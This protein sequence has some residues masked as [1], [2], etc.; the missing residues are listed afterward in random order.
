MKHAPPALPELSRPLRADKISAGGVVETI[1]AKP[2]EREALAARFGV[3]GVQKLEATLNVD[4]AKGKMFAVTGTL[5]A[6]VVQPCVVTLEPITSKIVDTI[7]V[8][9]APPQMLDKGAGPA[10]AEVGEEETPEPIVDGVID[11][12]ELVAQH[13]AIAIPLYPRR[14]GVPL[15]ET[16]LGAATKTV[17]TT[18]ATYKPFEKL[19][20][21]G[22]KPEKK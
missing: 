14:A 22:E 7:D 20:K 17:V 2:A 8:L 13:L 12:G 11:L 4:P 18:M 1:V 5:S 21:S 6:E 15:V 16:E 9:F 19:G 10:Q 3:L